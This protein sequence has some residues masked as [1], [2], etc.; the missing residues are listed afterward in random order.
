MTACL[1]IVFYALVFLL[2]LFPQ[3]FQ[4]ITSSLFVCF[5][6]LAQLSQSIIAAHNC[7]YISTYFCFL[8]ITI[9]SFHVSVLLCTQRGVNIF[10]VSPGFSHPYN[11]KH[12]VF[13]SSHALPFNTASTQHNIP[14]RKPLLFPMSCTHYITGYTEIRT[15]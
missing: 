5:L 12:E 2:P 4:Y 15:G 9:V 13:Y 10:P 6:F 14:I 1:T 8:P 7:L 11:I 3:Y